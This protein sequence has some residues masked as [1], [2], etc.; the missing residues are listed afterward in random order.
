MSGDPRTRHIESIRKTVKKIKKLKEI[1][2]YL[3]AMAYGHQGSGKTKMASTAP[4]VLIIDMNE[5]GTRSGSKSDGYGINVERWEQ[6]PDLYWYLKSGKHNY[7]SVALDTL[8]GMQGLCMSFVMRGSRHEAPTRREYGQTGVLMSGM[9]TAFRNLPM[10]VFFTAQE[11]TLWEGEGDDREL[12]GYTIDLPA[13]SRTTAL[14]SVGIV[15]HLEPKLVR[16]RTTKK[17]GY[18]DQFITEPDELYYTKVRPGVDLDPTLKKPTVPML[19]DAW[20]EKKGA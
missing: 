19:I 1:D 2:P 20:L 16:D 9:V 11:R 6:V 15:G 17:K 13:S 12:V 5:Q 4:D 3:K 7:K 10:H 14:A 8:T 18:L